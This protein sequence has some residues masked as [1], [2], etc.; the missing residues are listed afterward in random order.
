MNKVISI[1]I[2]GSIFQ[3]EEQAY[4]KL[5]NYLN[6]LKKHYGNKQEGAEIITDIENRIADYKNCYR[7]H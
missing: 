1:N 4:E 6:E 3:V 5:Y 7:I 2:G